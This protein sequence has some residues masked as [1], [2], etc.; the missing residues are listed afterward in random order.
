MIWLISFFGLFSSMMLAASSGS[1]GST[2]SSEGEALPDDGAQGDRADDSPGTPVENGEIYDGEDYDGPTLIDGPVISVQ[3][4][5][6]TTLE[7]PA[8]LDVANVEI[9][10]SPAV[11]NITVNPDGTLA[12]VLSSTSFFGELDFAYRVTDSDGDSTEYRGVLDVQ[13]PIVPNGWA[14]GDS[15][16][17]FATDENN[18]VVVETGDVHRKVYISESEDA[19]SRADIAALENLDVSAITNSWLASNDEYGGSEGMAVDLDVGLSI[20]GEIAGPGKEPSSHWLMF[21]RGYDYDFEFGLSFGGWQGESELH[22]IHVTS[23]GEGERPLIGGHLFGINHDAANIVF[24]DIAVE[25]TSWSLVGDN[26]IFEDVSFGAELALFNREGLT[27]RGSDFLDIHLDAPRGDGDWTTGDRSQGIFVDGVT[28][29]LLEHNLFDLIGWEP[30]YD[31]EGSASD[32]MPPN[33]FS[34]NIYLQVTT[35]DV[36]VRDN[37]S[38]RAAAYGLQAR[39]GGFIEDNVFLSNNIGLFI[40]DGDT[41]PTGQHALAT[42][43]LVTSAGAKELLGPGAFG[44]GITT[45]SEFVN[46]LDNIVA[47]AADPNNPDEI[48]R[49]VGEFPSAHSAGPSSGF[50]NTLIFN[51]LNDTNGGQSDVSHLDTDLLNQTTIQQLAESLNGTGTIEGFSEYLRSFIDTELD[52]T[53]GADDVIAYFQNA[54]GILPDDRAASTTLTFIPHPLGDGLRWDNRLNWDTEDLPSEEFIDSVDLNGNWVYY[55]GTTVIDDLDFG[56]GGRL[57]FNHG[58]LDVQ[59]ETLADERGGSVEIHGAG[60]L[61]FE[62]YRDEDL[63]EISTDGGRLANTGDVTGNL[64]L[65]VQD[66]A[67]I[68]LASDDASYE[69]GEGNLLDVE[70]GDTKIGFDGEA[71]GTAVLQLTEGGTLRLTAVDGE[72]ATIE[73]FRSGALGDATDVR[74]GI[75]LGNGRLELD[76]TELSG[77]GS[78]VLMDVDALAGQFE[79]IQLIGLGGNQDAVLSIDYSSDQV[80]LELLAPGSGAGDF[81]ISVSGDET[82]DSSDAELWSALTEGQPAFGDDTTHLYL[83]DEL[84]QIAAA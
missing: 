34:H 54:F 68:I 43:N 23:W 6:V 63:L 64:D 30:G 50:D 9:I 69:I 21:E 57:T 55:G 48:A 60:Q 39:S 20:W 70:G 7:L 36:T 52:D 38:M 61:W 83:D 26:I 16:Y 10:G 44:W 18:D 53:Y 79:E 45:G 40:N 31:P 15:H 82:D 59:G 8:D 27:I 46:Y 66:N 72:I 17:M 42:D 14:L 28:G 73:E 41:L 24:S 22:P 35:E 19:L 71:A 25:N 1:G 13:E 75:H 80:V 2:R 5:Q 67:Q 32:P 12:V 74:S 47:H 84:H 3:G 4:G 11:G 62:G 29:V 51:W 49:L 78:H 81:S 56:P 76:I 65:T 33:T 77:A 58:R 37:I